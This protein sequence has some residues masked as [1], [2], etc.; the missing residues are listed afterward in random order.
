MNTGQTRLSLRR[1][2]WTD[3]TAF[4]TALVPI[5]AWIVYFAWTPDWTG[6][7]A[8]IKPEA[9]PVFLALAILATLVSLVILAARFQ[10]LFKIFREGIEVKGKITRSELRRDRGRVEY[11]YIYEHKEYFSSANV[12]RNLQTKALK[13]GE[14]VVLMVDRQ[15]PS[16]AFIRD[17]YTRQ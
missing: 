8:V 3:Y 5:V 4:Y 12:H 13:S 9:Q 1:I 7:G 11:V 10:L 2:L 15:K 17:L 6:K 14:H 16:R